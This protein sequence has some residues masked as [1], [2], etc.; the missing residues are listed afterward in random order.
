MD[1]IIAE[2]E[3][4]KDDKCDIELMKFPSTF[5]EVSEWIFLVHEWIESY[6]ELTCGAPPPECQIKMLW[7]ESKR[8]KVCRTGLP[9]KVL[10]GWGLCFNGELTEAI[11]QFAEKVRIAYYQFLLG[12]DWEALDGERLRSQ[13]FY[14]PLV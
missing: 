4:L 5:D 8:C 2:I 12:I 1:E 11:S 6:I 13:Y 14:E 9:S 3:R 7:K 10:S